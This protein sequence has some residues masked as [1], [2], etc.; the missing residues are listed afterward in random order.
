M[1]VCIIENATLR[2]AVNLGNLLQFA[3]LPTDK[4][5][6]KLELELSQILLI[7]K[8]SSK[9]LDDPSFQNR[10]LVW[11]HL[12][13]IVDVTHPL[14][15]KT[16]FGWHIECSNFYIFSSLLVFPNRTWTPSNPFHIPMKY[17][18]SYQLLQTMP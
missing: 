4:I 10:K 11:F 15:D 17:S 1:Q 16:A 14:C 13:W 9:L 6:L 12:D 8:T 18:T 3:G 5:W 2:I 7:P